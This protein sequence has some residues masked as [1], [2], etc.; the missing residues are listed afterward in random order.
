MREGLELSELAVLQNEAS[1]IR[2]LNLC[3]GQGRHTIKLAGRFP[4]VN[5]QGID[6]STYLLNIARK[7]AMA[8]QVHIS[9]TFEGDARQ[10]PA[11][12]DSLI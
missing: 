5:F 10:I 6:Q 11:A 12:D 9:T 7:R 4:S 3:C 2:A 8:E 1:P